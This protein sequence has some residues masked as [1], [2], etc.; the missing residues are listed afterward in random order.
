MTY[1]ALVKKIKKNAYGTVASVERA[2]GDPE[3]ISGR[4]KEGLEDIVD[5][6]SELHNEVQSKGGYVAVAKKVGKDLVEKVS[7]TYKSIENKLFTEGKFDNKKVN[8]IL[9]DKGKAI[10]DYGVKA[11]NTLS[12]SVGKGV[13]SVKKD[14]RNFI[15]SDEEL[16]T[17]YK[18]IGTNYEGVLFRENYEKCL[19]FYSQVN[20]ELKGVKYR[21]TILEDIKASASGSIEELK[22]F[23]SQTNKYENKKARAVIGVLNKY[24]N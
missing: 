3:T 20:E 17:K 4:M 15:P 11:Y 2:L 1:E 19:E 13:D 9:A 22:E 5:A 18:G 10:A 14:Y 7:Q 12:E 16:S 23:Y 8:K 6:G 21:K 24:S